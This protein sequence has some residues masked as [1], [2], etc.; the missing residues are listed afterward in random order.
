MIFFWQLAFTFK[1]KR[2][3]YCHLA[4]VK[5]INSKEKTF[6]DLNLTNLAAVILSNARLESPSNR[7]N[8]HRWNKI[9]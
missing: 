7:T 2:S 6:T 5:K 9:S 3:L 4:Q 8:I 1:T